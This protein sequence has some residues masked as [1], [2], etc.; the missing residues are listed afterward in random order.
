MVFARH[1]RHYHGFAFGQDGSGGGG[2]GIAGAQ[3]ARLGCFW[4]VAAQQALGVRRSDPSAFLGDADGNN[5]VFLLI[6][7]VQDRGGRKQRDFVLAAAPA[8]QDTYPEFLHD[9]I[10]T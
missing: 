1:G 2:L 4:Q 5:V 6:D 9:C 8:E 7:G 10:L 3:M